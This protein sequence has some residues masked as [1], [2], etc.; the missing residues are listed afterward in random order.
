MAVEVITLDQ[1]LQTYRQLTAEHKAG[2]MVEAQYAAAL[3]KL[4]GI[5]PNGHWWGVQ[6]GGKFWMHDGTHWVPAIPPGLAAAQAPLPTP[7]P[8]RPNVPAQAHAAGRAGTPGHTVGEGIQVPRQAQA[9]ANKVTALLK[10]TPVLAVLPSVVCGSLWF[11]YTFLGLFK[12]E[13]L[14]GV[15]WLTPVIIGVIP[16]LLWIFK[17]QVDQL[18]MPFK[19]MVTALAKPLRL[20][21]VMAIP[22]LLGC[23]CSTLIPGGYLSLNVTSFIGVAT[24]AILMRY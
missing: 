6:P 23:T 8:L 14:V 5:D 9:A 11:L 15:D 1:M 21:I 16:V 19:P 22:V 13:Q 7:A 20:G 18:L 2:R 3:A 12:G 24:A 17:K 10:A 4:Q